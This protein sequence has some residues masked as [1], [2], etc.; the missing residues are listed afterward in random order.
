MSSNEDNKM[1][2]THG[3]FTGMYRKRNNLKEARHAMQ[4]MDVFYDVCELNTTK[5][6]LWKILSDDPREVVEESIKKFEKRDKKASSKFK[7]NLKKPSNA[8]RIFIN[9]MIVPKHKGKSAPD[10]NSIAS[11]EWKK[12]S[13][14][15]KKKYQTTANTER[16]KY[17]IEKDIEFKE[18]VENGKFEE[19]KPKKPMSSYLIFIHNKEK[20]EEERETNEFTNN[21]ELRNH[22]ISLWKEMSDD[23]KTPWKVLQEKAKENYKKEFM[24]YN[25]RV[26]ERKKKLDSVANDDD[27]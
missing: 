13:D 10:I 22:M 4:I 23:D 7:S 17:Q 14:A 24:V 16:A 5:E 12:M 20:Q 8:Y 25:E 11:E 27:E 1:S 18:A 26:L 6:E 21:T 3:K 19:P 2:S 15:K 9:D